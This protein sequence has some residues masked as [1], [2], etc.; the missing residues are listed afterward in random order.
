[1]VTHSLLLD[2]LSSYG[3]STGYVNWFCSYLTN[4]QFCVRFT[5][6]FS[7][8]FIALPQGSVLEPLLFIIY[9]NDRCSKITH[10]NFLFLPDDVKIFRRITSIDHCILLQS[11]INSEQN[12]CTANHMNINAVKTKVISFSRR[13]NTLTLN[14]V[15]C[16]TDILRTDCTEDLGVFLDFKL[17]FDQHVDYLFSDTITLLG[18]IRTI[19]FSFSSLDSLMMLYISLVRSKLEYA[20]VA[21]N[22][23]TNTDS[24]KLERIQKK[25]ATIYYNR[26]FKNHN[27][28]VSDK[29][30]L[31]T[32]HVRRRYF[33][34]LFIRNV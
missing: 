21:W 23:L 14:Y 33:D 31:N 27:P 4:R 19:T 25:F 17:C 7:S 16:N 5:G 32:L 11:A 13:P 12:W 3:L 18:L 2:K 9:M 30:K 10:C 1:L 26:F 8:P 15:I 29:L 6:I 22:S 28:Y 34:V 20:S 24:N